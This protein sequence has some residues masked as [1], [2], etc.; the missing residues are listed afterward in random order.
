M[1]EADRGVFFREVGTHIIIL[2]VHVDDCMITG[3]SGKLIS[4]F[5]REINEKHKI[6]DLGPAH[7]LLGIKITRD[8]A[9]KTIALSQHS[10][11]ESIITRFNFDDLKPLSTPMDPSIQLL[12]SQSPT[13]LVNIAK[14]KNVPYRE[15][16]GSL[17]YAAME[18]RPDIAFATSTVAQFSEHPRWVHWKAV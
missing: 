11:I 3:S 7:W 8:L 16:V 18:T 10:Y 6:T 13:K 15:A 9:N 17:M 14:M 1:R 4:V 12:K 2:A 5:K